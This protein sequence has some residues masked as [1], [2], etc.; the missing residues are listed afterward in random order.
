MK[1]SVIVS[2]ASN[3]DEA[4]FNNLSAFQWAIAE[5]TVATQANTAL[6]QVRRLTKLIASGDTALA[7]EAV[8][9]VFQQTA[10]TALDA[11]VTSDTAPAAV[12]AVDLLTFPIRDNITAGGSTGSVVGQALFALENTANIP[13]IDIKVDS[14]A[15]TA[16]TKKLKAKWT[17]E[18]GQ[19]LNAYHNLD[20]EVELTSIL[21]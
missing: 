4:D 10:G 14:I 6:T 13:E 8:R 9:F 2:K 12:S 18:L 17:P 11:V 20:A 3:A 21:S 15:I 16:Q 7:E 19:D 1:K 5:A